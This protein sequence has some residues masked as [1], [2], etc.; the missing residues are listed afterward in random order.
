MTKATIY[1]LRKD[2][3]RKHCF[4]KKSANMA[5]SSHQR[6]N[7]RRHTLLNKMKATGTNGGRQVF[8]LYKLVLLL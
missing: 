7:Q 1:I 4:N 3:K 2:R 5:G 6:N 8:V